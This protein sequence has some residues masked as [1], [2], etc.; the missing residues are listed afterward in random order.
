MRPD[1]ENIFT[2]RF[3]WLCDVP[4]FRLG[5][6]QL[7]WRRPR[8]AIGWESTM[9]TMLLIAEIGVFLLLAGYTLAICRL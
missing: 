1:H 5:S 8:K 3:Q 9:L 2:E 6:L 4:H 7:I